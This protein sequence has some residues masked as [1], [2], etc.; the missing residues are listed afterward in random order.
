[1]AH[2]IKRPKKKSLTEIQ[3]L[4][5]NALNKYV[6]LRGK[7]S[8]KQLHTNTNDITILK[9]RKMFICSVYGRIK[10]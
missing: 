7:K 5:N 4:Y 6:M 1:M 3:Q 8:T 2:F 10:A 9:V